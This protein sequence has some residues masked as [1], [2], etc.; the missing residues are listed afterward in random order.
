MT[1][2][3]AGTMVRR[4]GTGVGAVPRHAASPDGTT[5]SCRLWQ[6]A[7]LS[8]FGSVRRDAFGQKI[9]SDGP[10]ESELGHVPGTRFVG[11]ASELSLLFGSPVD[12][13]TR[14]AVERS[15]EHVRPKEIPEAAEVVHAAR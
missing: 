11:M 9:R 2:R 10:V 1:A 13:P 6:F 7:E 4:S 14:S 15:P 8:L 3:P 5:D 12:V